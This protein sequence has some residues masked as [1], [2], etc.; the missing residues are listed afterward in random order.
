PRWLSRH[1]ASR[2]LWAYVDLAAAGDVLLAFCWSHVRRNLY[3]IQVAT[4]APIAAE[5]LM[6]IATFYATEEMRW[7]KNTD[8]DARAI[9]ATI[10]AERSAEENVSLIRRQVEQGQVNI[11]LLIA[12]QQAFLQTSLA[13][14]DAQASRLA[15]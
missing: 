10:A 7:P 9:N 4:P 2:W 6:R 15:D 11:A 1:P 5:A 8:Y 14:A 13:R 12:A 3:D